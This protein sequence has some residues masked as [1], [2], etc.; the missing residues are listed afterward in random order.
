[1]PAGSGPG[2]P[3]SRRAGQPEGAALGRHG[4]R[5]PAAAAEC[6][7]RLAAAR[8]RPRPLTGPRQRCPSL[9]RPRHSPPPDRRYWGSDRDPAP[10]ARSSRW[11]A[12]LD[13][14][15]TPPPTAHWPQDSQLRLVLLPASHWLMPTAGPPWA[16][17]S[18]GNPS[19][20]T[21]A[22]P[23]PHW[24]R[25]QKPPGYDDVTTLPSG[26]PLWSR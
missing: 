13:K 10:E 1:M 17:R 26:G 5:I 2:T 23:A 12:V 14:A 16:L 25:P 11:L 9:G 21:A 3:R 18:L 6:L 4:A 24:P 19:T 20:E 8:P 22:A 7:S 15:R